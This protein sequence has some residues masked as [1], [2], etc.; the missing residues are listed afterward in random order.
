[1]RGRN[2]TLYNAFSNTIAASQAATG[3]CPS[4][5]I[6]AA[7]DRSGAASPPRRRTRS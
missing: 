1:M 2:M 4:G 5:A 7:I 3:A 6:S